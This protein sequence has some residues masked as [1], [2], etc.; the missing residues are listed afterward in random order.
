MRNNYYKPNG[1]TLWIRLLCAVLFVAFTFC[2]LFFYQ[3]EL[4][5]FLQHVLSQGLTRYNKII[6]SVIITTVLYL[7]HVA[8]YYLIKIPRYGCALSYFPSFLLLA[9]FTDF[10]EEIVNRYQI[11]HWSWALPLLTFSYIVIVL[12][13]KRMPDSGKS[14]RN[15]HLFW[16]DGWINFLTI[17][18]MMLF[19]GGIADGNEIFH[20][21]LKTENKL[22][23]NDF[24]GACQEGIHSAQTDSSLV[25][26]RAFALSNMNL[27]GEKLFEYP[28]MGGSKSLLPNGKS[29]RLLFY[30]QKRFFQHFSDK[31]VSS[32]QPIDCF[33]TLIQQK[34]AKNSVKDYLLC[35][36]LLDK[37]ID[38]FVGYLPRF[39][40]I[41]SLL[42]KHYREALILYMHYRSNP[43]I[44]YR[45]NVMD[46]DY[47]DYQELEKEYPD[48]AERISHLRD[49]YGK[50][51]WFYFKY[52]NP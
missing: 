5:T 45:N 21:R 4:L 24:Y 41:D 28:Q 36:F 17:S 10:G 23:E 18:L 47:S 15:K 44:I 25:M 26:L 27:L 48:K 52:S 43:Q 13:L 51:Y 32:Q 42:P 2:Y 39:Y 16:R 33:E 31:A 35:G 22:L 49:I 20:Y 6:G 11:G 29:V 14:G 9:L 3:A 19:V 38:K 1:N 37:Q 50:T 8:I 46:A 7:L 40:A 34:A 30:D 12:L